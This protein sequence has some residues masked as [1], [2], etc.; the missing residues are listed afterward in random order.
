MPTSPTV[1]H[2]ASAVHNSTTSLSS[3]LAATLLFHDSRFALFLC[4][5][6]FPGPVVPVVHAGNHLEVFDSRFRSIP[7]S[8]TF[9]A[10]ALP[11]LLPSSVH[12][13]K[14]EYNWRYRRRIASK[15]RNRVLY[16]RPQA[17][18]S[19]S[20]IVRIIMY[21]CD[22]GK[23]YKCARKKTP[24]DFCRGVARAFERSFSYEIYV[25]ENR[26]INSSCLL[27]RLWKCRKKKT[28]NPGTYR[29]FQ[30]HSKITTVSI[31]RRDLSIYL[32]LRYYKIFFG[33][34]R[35][36]A[37]SL[38][39]KKSKKSVAN[40]NGCAFVIRSSE[41]SS[42]SIDNTANMSWPLNLLFL[43]YL[44]DTNFF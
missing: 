42:G 20:A 11:A 24:W 14:C 7:L 30:D 10:P 3:F 15:S 18:T 17:T 27:Y 35:I 5:P 33:N 23:Q 40:K 22:H 1:Q 26:K 9:H 28:V 29:I 38:Q 41:K 36:F 32:W 2:L 13:P 43:G 39:C 6:V 19:C 44:H 37:K 31:H 34:Y 25:S 16:L 12:P 8:Y 4:S 21:L